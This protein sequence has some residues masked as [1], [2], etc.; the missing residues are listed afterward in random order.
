MII[1][2]GM[3]IG[4]LFF[5]IAGGYGLTKWIIENFLALIIGFALAIGLIVGWCRLLMNHPIIAL[6]LL[7]AFLIF[8]FIA[9]A[10]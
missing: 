2:T 7:A 4:A 3:V 8:I 10:A 1:T 6:I 5:L 9:V